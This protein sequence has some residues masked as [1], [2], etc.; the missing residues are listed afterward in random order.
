MKLEH[1]AAGPSLSG[2]EPTNV[3]SAVALVPLAEDSVRLICGAPDGVIKERLLGRADEA[4]II[5][6]QA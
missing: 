5:A 2:I 4:K 3:V 6:R 1:R